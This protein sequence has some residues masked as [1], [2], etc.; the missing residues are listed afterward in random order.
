MNKRLLCVII[1]IAIICGSLIALSSYTDFFQ[2][3]IPL[4]IQGSSS[5]NIDYAS[6]KGGLIIQ[7]DIAVWNNSWG[8]IENTYTVN[9]FNAEIELKLTS[10]ISSQN[11]KGC[12]IFPEKLVGETVSLN[13]T[14]QKDII[15]NDY[16]YVIHSYTCT[17]GNFEYTTEPKYVKCL[18]NNGSV[19]FEHYFDSGNLENA[20][21]EWNE[22]EIVGSHIEQQDY[23]GFKDVT[24]SF[25]YQ[26][27]DVP[28]YE[29]KEHVYCSEKY[30]N[31]GETVLLK[32]N[33]QKQPALN[34]Q[35]MKYW[36]CFWR[37]SDTLSEA[38][39][40]ENIVCVDP[41]WNSSCLNKISNNI[42]PQVTDTNH[43]IN[44]TLGYAINTSGTY[45]LLNATNTEIAWTTANKS[46]MNNI[47]WFNISTNAGNGFGV[48]I[49]YNC[50]S[51]TPQYNT[52][53]VM[54]EVFRMD[55]QAEIDAFGDI[56]TSG[57][58]VINNTY[59]VEGDGSATITTEDGS[60]R[61]NLRNTYT[62]NKSFIGWTDFKGSDAQVGTFQRWRILLNS[63][64]KAGIWNYEPT[65]TIK[66][67][68][69]AS[70]EFTS[71]IDLPNEWT[72]VR[73]DQLSNGSFQDFANG[74]FVIAESIGNVNELYMF[75]TFT[76][77]GSYD[78]FYIRDSYGKHS[79][80][81]TV[82]SEESPPNLNP[83]LVINA[84]TNNT[85]FTYADIDFNF[86]A[87][88]DSNTS[89]ICDVYID[90][91]LNVSVG[92]MSGELN[93][94]QII[95]FTDTIHTFYINVSDSE[96]T[97]QTLINTFIVN[98]I[99][100][101]IFLDEPTNKTYN[102]T[103][104]GVNVSTTA[105]D[106]SSRYYSLNNS[107]Y[108]IFTGN[109]T[110]N[111][112]DGVYNLDVII[113]D[114]ANNT[115]SSSI[116]FSID[117]SSPNITFLVQTPSNIISNSAVNTIVKINYTIL[118]DSVISGTEFYYKTNNSVTDD[119][120]F[121]NGTVTSGFKLL[122]DSSINYSDIWE[123]SLQD[124][125][126]YPSTYNYAPELM[127]TYAKSVYVIDSFSEY[128][129]VEFFN[130]SNNREFNLIEAY[131]DNVTGTSQG[132]E[133]FGC[134]KSYVS[135]N[136]HLSSNCV[137]F[138]T[139]PV[140]QQFNNT[141]SANSKHYT[142]PMIINTTTG[143]LG[144]IY[145]TDTFYILLKGVNPSND[146]NFYYMTNVSRID[147]MQTT[148]NSGSSWSN[149]SGTF[150]IQIH[151]FSGNDYFRYY[152][153][154]N[155]TF[156]FSNCSSV[157]SDFLDIGIANPT[158][159]IVQIPEINFE[160]NMTFDIVFLEAVGFNASINSYNLSLL[161]PNGTFNVTIFSNTTNLTL[162]F[163]TIPYE[164]GTYI[165]QIEALDEFGYSSF[166]FSENFSIMNTYTPVPTH[167]PS[168]NFAGIDLFSSALYFDF[169][170]TNGDCYINVTKNNVL[171]FS[172]N[173][174]N[175]TNGQSC[176][177][178]IIGANFTTGD[179]WSI[180]YQFFGERYSYFGYD[181]FT[182]LASYMNCSYDSSPYIKAD[183]P[184]TERDKI[185]WFCV[186][187]GFTDKTVD[188]MTYVS[189]KGDLIQLNPEPKYVDGIG[190]VSSFRAKPE[191]ASTQSMKVHF[192]SKDLR[193]NKQV[194]FTVLCNLYQSGENDFEVLTITNNVTPTYK[195]PFVMI[196]RGSWANRNLAY[197]V[198]GVIIL[199][200]IF[201]LIIMVRRF[202]Q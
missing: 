5:Q 87:T 30:V 165:L 65:N 134:N 85:L 163:N 109:I 1:F 199:I 2:K 120:I 169:N 158:S 95:G 60:K 99:H 100:P 43:Q 32:G 14:W 103:L 64:H 47:F 164:D 74:I 190:E 157:R 44:I 161:N 167:S 130:V 108:I 183:I 66:F 143:N 7:D 84:P 106:E 196:D 82:G 58:W 151:Q 13:G 46:E 22:W 33:L 12:W 160:Y 170:L 129:K 69:G 25:T 79:A 110:L 144:N 114:T 125:Q 168:D 91:V 17:T 55:N 200:V 63:V 76:R 121:I 80:I 92:C 152:V 137:S 116:A 48:D 153:C 101:D 4:S 188:C 51:N 184:F 81:V 127:D 107:D 105:I 193:D 36:A 162:A 198:Y 146:W 126:I 197:L 62:G 15:V 187:K 61:Q 96:L 186:L 180:K 42:I 38:W 155:D 166:G 136:V 159:P 176:N 9:G 19:M 78:N 115:N 112:G 35:S 179:N 31:Q 45:V 37:A 174:S 172:Y 71:G 53:Q 52:T 57:T 3:S 8:S 24:S 86:T 97:N 20:Y 117:T 26:E 29:G 177:I 178:T 21:I 77:D 90:G 113:N 201:F 124:H 50:S 119:F 149:F 173:F 148:T 59:F 49:Y 133:V 150:D 68:Y 11:I 142:I 145:V 118:D 18:E 182:V 122:S 189:Y 54:E 147:A 27:V 34:S 10:N 93:N 185:D 139:V 73:I 6:S 104:I 16:D 70:S 191:N 195:D 98:A 141:H 140:T 72:E 102:I 202:L 75:Y 88:D 56:S 123:F 41:Y 89:M 171:Q 132:L 131:I 181:N 83:T 40:N 39:D 135:G 67:V 28:I 128:V 111:L 156:N 23:D 192:D 154:A 175:Y 94:T 194:N 138:Y